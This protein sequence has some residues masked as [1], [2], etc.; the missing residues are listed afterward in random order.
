M[1]RRFVLGLALALLSGAS[2]ST[3]GSFAKGL[4]E[5][6]WTPG[7]AVTARV[8]LA[9]LVL[10]VPAVV[11]MRG[12][13]HTL[14][15]G[16]PQIVLFGLVAVAGCQLAYFFAVQRLTVGVAL[17]LEY[18]GIILI[19]GWL[20]LRHG[21]RPRPLTVAGAGLAVAGLALVLDVFGGIQIDLVGV[22]FGLAAAM[23]LA[24]YFIVSADETHQVP[25]ITLATGGLAVGA[26]VLL[27]A[28]A[29]GVLPM[30]WST[31]HVV[32]AGTQVPMWLDAVLLAVVAGALA[33]FSGIAATRR[34][35]SKLA[36][37]VGLT[38]VMFAVLFA[39]L[40]LGE[41][42][43]PIQLAGGVLILAGVVAVKLDE[44]PR[45][46]VAEPEPRTE[47][48]PAADPVPA[49]TPDD[50][51]SPDEVGAPA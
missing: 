36:S 23:G 17:L 41:L 28:G 47:A 14:R 5:A 37:F 21:H 42:P 31:E 3:S 32:L 11:A 16:W 13:W 19:V 8:G 40:L 4:L 9:A 18:L 30:R 50:V 15:R 12:R 38:E 27:L 29:V 44:R 25:P 49:A 1:D 2:F 22:L 51:A 7:A 24:V 20:W 45:P 34:L 6:G 10:L 35:G 39:W 43:A 48:Q 33:Y 26:L 46:A